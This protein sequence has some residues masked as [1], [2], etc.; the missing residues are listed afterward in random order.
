MEEGE[1]EEDIIGR[2]GGGFVGDQS[3][4]KGGIGQKWM[5]KNSEAGFGTIIITIIIIIIIIIIVIVSTSLE[6]K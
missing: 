1:V 2:C 6:W 4:K 3:L 5:G